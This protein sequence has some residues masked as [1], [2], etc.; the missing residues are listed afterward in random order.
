LEFIEL[1]G[2]PWDGTEEV[3]PMRSVKLSIDVIDSAR[4]VAA[5][6]GD[7]MSEMISNILRPLLGEL[8][9]EELAKRAEIRTDT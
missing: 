2:R 1:Q 5:Y 7:T 8:L 6:R 4:I 9:A 3:A